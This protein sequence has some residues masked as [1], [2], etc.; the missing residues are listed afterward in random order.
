V[1]SEDEG[2]TGNNEDGDDMYGDLGGDDAVDEE[3]NYYDTFICV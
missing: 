1:N 2:S 3:V